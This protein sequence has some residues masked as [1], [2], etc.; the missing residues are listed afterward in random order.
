MAW[1]GRVSKR[2]GASALIMATGAGLVI[3][4]QVGS[5]SHAVAAVASSTTVAVPKSGTAV[6]GQSVA[7]TAAVS[8]TP[9]NT[10]GV[11]FLDNGGPISPVRHSTTGRYSFSTTT[12][13]MGAHSITASFTDPSGALA[14]STSAPAALTVSAAGTGT[15]TMVLTSNPPS[16][17]QGGTPVSLTAQ[18][19]GSAGL[20]T[21]TGSV[22]FKNGTGVISAGRGVGANGAVTIPANTLPLGTN[23]ISAAYSGDANYAAVTQ[24]LPLVVTASQNDKFVQHLY[25]DMIGGQDPGGEAYWVSQLVKGA[26]RPAVAYAFTQT[27]N[28]DNA[29]VNQLYLNIMQRPADAGG[30]SYWAGQ[31]RGGSTPERVAAS[32]V[33]LPERYNSQAFGQ[34]NDDTWIAATY[35][36][37]LGRE[38][39]PSGK[40]YWHNFLATGGPR[41]QMTLDFV[42]GSEWAGVTVNTMYAKFHLG[43]PDPGALGYWS[44]QVLGGMR[45]DRLAAQLTG[46]QQ[47]FDWAQAN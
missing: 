7:L 36:A 43:T 14:P 23:N 6:F 34:G 18:L 21:P 27:Q 39:E 5:T 44:G 28:Y 13:A 10:A 46:S 11:T 29:V 4:Q 35:R 41:W 30:A 17:V 47:Y 1:F 9:S 8:P 26:T 42:S 2:G 19:T 24:T 25:T 40:A 20:P 15:A 22:T 37:L 32:M 45:D 16:P 3:S 38:G 31:L 33:A 12:L